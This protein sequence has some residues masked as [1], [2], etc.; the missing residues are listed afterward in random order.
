MTI[1]AQ[2]HCRTCGRDMTDEWNGSDCKSNECS[3]CVNSRIMQILH[4]HPQDNDDVAAKRVA[5]ATQSKDL[6]Q[7]PQVWITCPCGTRLLLRYSYKCWECGIFFC[8]S[9]AE[10]HFGPKPA[11]ACVGEELQ[12]DHEPKRGWADCQTE[13]PDFDTHPGW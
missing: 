13:R 3:I 6:N 1:P 7:Q 10:K 11:T 2:Y 5:I 9:C 8:R 12:P 4:R